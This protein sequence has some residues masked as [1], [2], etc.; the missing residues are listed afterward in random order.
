MK[1]NR[2]TEGRS[3]LKRSIDMTSSGMNDLNIRTNTSPIWDRTR[4]LEDHASSVLLA[5]TASNVVWKPP[6]IR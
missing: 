3:K 5:T 4:R 2:I 6:G 1:Q